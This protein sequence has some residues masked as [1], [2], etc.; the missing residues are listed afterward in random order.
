MM[1]LLLAH[2]MVYLLACFKQW[3]GGAKLEEL[4]R[5]RKSFSGLQVASGWKAHFGIHK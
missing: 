4:S 2:G 1:C 5:R 3:A